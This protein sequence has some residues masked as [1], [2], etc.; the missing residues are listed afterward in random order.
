MI[1]NKKMN[2]NIKKMNSSKIY[3]RKLQAILILKKKIDQS[4][5]TMSK[6]LCSEMKN[7]V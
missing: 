7:R 2:M 3:Y 6:N 1:V 4:N 5:D